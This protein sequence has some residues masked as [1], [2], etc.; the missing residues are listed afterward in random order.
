MKTSLLEE[1]SHIRELMIRQLSV[2]IEEKK[3]IVMPAALSIRNNEYMKEYVG[4]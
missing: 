3:N 4:N 1:G 2:D